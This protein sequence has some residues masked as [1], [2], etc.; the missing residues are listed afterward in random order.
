VPAAVP[1][2]RRALACAALAAGLLAAAGGCG[3]GAAGEG[4][5]PARGHARPAGGSVPEAT[6]TGVGT[7]V[8]AGETEPVPHEGDAAD[9]AAIWVDRARPPRSVVVGS[10]KKGGIAVYDL[11][12]RELQYRPDG[13]MNSVDLRTGVPL[14]GRRV[15]LVTAGDRDADTI[16]VYRLDPASRRLVPV[17]TEPI[18]L[19]L[20]VYGSCMYRSARTGAVDVV[21]TSKDGEVEQW[22]LAGDARGRVRARLV[23]RLDVGG[24]TEGCVADDRHAALYLGEED[25][26]IWRY[27]AEPGAGAR[28]TLV[29]ATGQRGHLEADVEGLALAGGPGG[30]GHLVASSQGD[31]TF[32]VYRRTGGNAF[33]GRFRIAAGRGVDAVTDTDGIEVTTTGLGGAFPAGLLVAHD[34]DNG[35][36]HQNFK[37][38]AWPRGAFRRSSGR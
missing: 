26:G 15:T 34:G 36:E 23:R 11:A 6:A 30:T 20:R 4:D 37:L 27:G 2:L 32:A 5:G 22:R 31:S 25:R 35:D 33:V 13:D 17:A 24:Q 8:A 1:T 14:G 3:G 19:G 28:R 18:E 9:D 29:D 12:G 38:V 16:A 21:V 7:L 10:D